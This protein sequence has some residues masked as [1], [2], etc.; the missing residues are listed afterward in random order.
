MADPTVYDH[1][2]PTDGEAPAGIY[3]VVGTDSETVT[4]L[5]VGGP[6][7]HRINTGQVH[8]V[9]RDVLEGFAPAEN[10]DG[11][12]SGEA[13]L[14]GAAEVLYWSVHAFGRQ[15]VRQPL[16]TTAALALVV[17]G[18]VG[19]PFVNAP[20]ALFDVLVVVGALGLALVG[21]GRFS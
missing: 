16:L 10:P 8:R 15:L 11:N 20:E 18:S 1:L 3:R 6:D 19:E 9:D 12:R 4:L 7:G 17:V 14:T 21:G 5:R 2:R 13:A